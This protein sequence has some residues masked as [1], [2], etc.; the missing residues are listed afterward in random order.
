VNQISDLTALQA[1][2]DR[3]FSRGKKQRIKSRIIEL[4]RAA[5]AAK[6]EDPDAGKG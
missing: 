2:L 5:A 1:I 4:K 6:G 3:T